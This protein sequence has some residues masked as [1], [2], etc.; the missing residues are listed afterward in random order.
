MTENSE[1]DVEHSKSC[2]TRANLSFLPFEGDLTG[3]DV[4][5]MSEF[6]EASEGGGG[7]REPPTC[8]ELAIEGECLTKQGDHKE[9]IPLLESAL[10]MGT[11]DLQL[12][13]VLWSLLGNAHFYLGNYELAAVCHSHDLAVCR[14][15]G[16]ELNQ[17]QAYCNLGIAH[18]KVGYLQRARLCYERYLQLC[19]KV[20]DLRSKCKAHHNLGDLHLTL[21]RLK[22][23]RDK[24]DDTPE[25]K[26]HL[27]LAAQYFE[28]HLQFTRELENR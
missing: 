4:V 16:D 10:A 26:E 3:G 17:A 14:E 12:L 6:S 27:L 20:E 8:Q 24:L 5:S 28:N 13:S 15:L 1:Y 7:V 22:L 2:I 11:S 25:A 21:A 9:A 18:R 19:D 23:Q